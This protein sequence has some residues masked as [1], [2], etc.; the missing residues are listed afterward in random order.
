MGRSGVVLLKTPPGPAMAEARFY[1]PVTS[2]VRSV[3]LLLDGRQVASYPCPKP[4]IYTISS[5]PLSPAGSQV[6]DHRDSLTERSLSPV[7]GER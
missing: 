3:G 2:P 7:T 5:T 4:G 1:L 6:G